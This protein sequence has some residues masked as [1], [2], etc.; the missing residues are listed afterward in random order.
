MSEQ[1]PTSALKKYLDEFGSIENI[2]SND[3]E[4]YELTQKLI[5]AETSIHSS[6][7]YQGIVNLASSTKMSRASRRTNHVREKDLPAESV[8]TGERVHSRD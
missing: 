7:F 8:V 3:L 6:I 4:L 2:P 5:L 1:P